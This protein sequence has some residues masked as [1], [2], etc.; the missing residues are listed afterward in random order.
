MG[1]KTHKRAAGNA[2]IFG[3]QTFT[4]LLMEYFDFSSKSWFMHSSV[5]PP[6]IKAWTKIITCTLNHANIT[7]LELYFPAAHFQRI[8][9]EQFIIS[10]ALIFMVRGQL[11]RWA[12]FSS[13]HKI[14]DRNCVIISA[15]EDNLAI[16]SR[17]YTNVLW[18]QERLRTAFLLES[19]HYDSPNFACFRWKRF[20]KSCDEWFII[21]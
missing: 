7:N 18:H 15:L 11:H 14:S 8:V 13:L 17:I 16:W 2:A 9:K 10:F 20:L 21:S 1:A 12:V 4:L 3:V 5:L 6:V 19:C